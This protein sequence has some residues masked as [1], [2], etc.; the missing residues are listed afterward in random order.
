MD[1]NDLAS[2]AH[3]R[4]SGRKKEKNSQLWK[5]NC[6]DG[7]D[8]SEQHHVN[9]LEGTWT[10]APKHP[11]RGYFC[12]EIYQGRN[13]AQQPPRKMSKKTCII[14]G[15]PLYGREA[16][17]KLSVVMGPFLRK[18][19]IIDQSPLPS[20]SSGRSV[21]TSPHSAAADV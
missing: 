6:C 5:A 13:E 10:P 19:P 16:K 12:G 1:K 3:M 18:P 20:P 7:T 17:D 9:V 2:S 21:L 8:L 15:P 4:E 11:L 14:S